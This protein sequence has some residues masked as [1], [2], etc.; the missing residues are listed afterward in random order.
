MATKSETGLAV[1]MVNFDELNLKVSGFGARYNPSNT[2]ITASALTALSGDVKGAVE[3]TARAFALRTSAADAREEAFGQLGPR[4]TQVIN[5]FGVCGVSPQL[6]DSANTFVRKIRGQRVT[7]L[8]TEEE[9]AAQAAEGKETKQI[10]ASQLGYD[11]RIENFG[12]LIDLIETVPQYAPN[13]DEL[14]TKNLREFYN[15]LNHINVF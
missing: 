12:K 10:S 4:V 1:N 11:N 7:P 3:T 2:T 6:L 13:E 14:T 9:K 5:A 15:F 8:L